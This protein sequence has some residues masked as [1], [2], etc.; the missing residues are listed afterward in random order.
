MHVIFGIFWSG[1]KIGIDV[2][3]FKVFTCLGGGRK[4]CGVSVFTRGYKAR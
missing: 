3:V 1:L 2:D 4:R